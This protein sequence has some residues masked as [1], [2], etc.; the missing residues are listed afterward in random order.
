MV[1]CSKLVSSSVVFF[2]SLAILQCLFGMLL[3]MF[4]SMFSFSA[5]ANS[6]AG[7][8]FVSFAVSNFTSGK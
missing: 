8:N 2:R 4:L 5:L 1:I 7:C 6:S 3:M